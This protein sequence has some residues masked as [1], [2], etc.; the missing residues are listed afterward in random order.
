VVFLA[1]DLLLW[2]SSLQQEHALW[3]TELELIGLSMVLKTTIPLMALLQ[4][5]DELGF[6]VGDRNKGVHCKI[7]EDKNGAPAIASMPKTRPR[8][9]HINKFFASSTI[10]IER[11]PA[12]ASARS[13]C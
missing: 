11:T 9:K 5:M 2:K 1:G 7:F 12:T 4:E 10:R 8:T 3:S 6:P 13:T